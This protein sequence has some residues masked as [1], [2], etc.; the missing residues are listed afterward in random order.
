MNFANTADYYLLE[1]LLVLGRTLAQTCTV[2]LQ[3]VDRQ[4][5]LPQTQPLPWSHDFALV[6]S[7]MQE[8]VGGA[9]TV[10]GQHTQ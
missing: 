4:A 5:F 2:P 9:N 3:F 1:P 8:D 10:F 7:T 6:S